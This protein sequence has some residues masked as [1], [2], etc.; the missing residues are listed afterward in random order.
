MSHPSMIDLK[1]GT[2]L[3]L[4][5]RPDIK[6]DNPIIR[7]EQA[8]KSLTKILKNGDQLISPQ[9]GSRHYD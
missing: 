8:E 6:S 9:I 4:T 2:H 1:D 7:Q 5:F 3:Q